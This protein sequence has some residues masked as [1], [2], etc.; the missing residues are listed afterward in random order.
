M[1]KV[2]NIDDAEV[3]AFIE[4][5]WPTFSPVL[6]PQE[7]ADAAYVFTETYFRLLET[8]GSPTY[9]HAMARRVR[10][11][12]LSRAVH[13][14]PIADA[15]WH[16]AVPGTPFSE[17]VLARR[18]AQLDAVVDRT[19]RAYIEALEARV[20]NGSVT[21]ADA[22]QAYAAFRSTLAAIKKVRKRLEAERAAPGTDSE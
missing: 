13:S 9:G 20:S 5:F 15:F 14:D 22:T 21:A 12:V 17:Q 18:R 16:E 19:E 7:R 4:R 2:G 11:R 8:E 6:T 3:D 1:P 10:H